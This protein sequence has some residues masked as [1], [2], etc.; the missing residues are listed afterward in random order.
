LPSFVGFRVEHS[1][2]T[3]AA[4]VTFRE[5]EVPSEEEWGTLRS[6][7]SLVWGDNFRF[8]EQEDAFVTLIKHKIKD[9]HGMMN[10][11]KDF[12]ESRILGKADGPPMG[13]LVRWLLLV[14]FGQV[15]FQHRPIWMQ[16]AVIAYQQK[17]GVALLGKSGTGKS[18]HSRRWLQQIPDT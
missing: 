17:Q 4:V 9:K 16:A 3:S 8:Y 1:N 2:K 11:T 18:T 15:G 12:R 10:R 13:A 6:D 14:V 7:I 5:E